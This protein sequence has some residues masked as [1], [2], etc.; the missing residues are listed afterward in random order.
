MLNNLRCH[1]TAGLLAL[2]ASALISGAV[3]SDAQARIEANFSAAHPPPQFDD[4]AKAVDAFKSALA[5]NDFDALAGLLG[6]DAAKLRA[7]EAS[8][9]TFEKLR[10]GAA[11][12]V[13]VKTLSPDRKVLDVGRELWPLPFPL[14]KNAEGKW[15][16]DTQAGLQEILNR[17]IGENEL[18]VIAT[19]RA[20]VEAQRSYA[21]TD[22]DGDGVF[23]YAQKL[24]S[25]PGKTDGLYWPAEQG[26]G[27]SPAGD[28]IGQGTI[29]R[30][31]QGEG[32]FGYRF[33][34]LRA[35]GAHVA[36]GRYDYVINGN[37]IAGFGLIAWPVV[38]GETGINSFVVNQAGIVYEK[39]LGPKTATIADEIVRFNPAS[40]WHISEE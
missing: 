28:A 19:L 5:G 33:R 34:I 11:E 4:P 2:A 36:G 40:S 30:G 6:L 39:D 3:V 18:E 26:D 17:R 8:T 13:D 12:A 24:V 15:A 21:L 20:Y 25:T 10:Q 9:S 14:V 1:I 31:K 29:D 32:Y 16:F 35:Q 23:E 37:M 38:Y 22:H 27:I 7:D